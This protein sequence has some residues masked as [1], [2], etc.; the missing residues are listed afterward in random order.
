MRLPATL[1]LPFFIFQTWA[2]TLDDVSETPVTRVVELLKQMQ[3]SLQK[4]MDEDAALYDKL[5]CWCNNNKY[6]KGEA[7]SDA[8]AKVSDVMSTTESLTSRR[9]EVKLVIEQLEKSVADGKATLDQ[10]AEMREKEAAEFHGSE[11]DSIQAVE[12]LKAA[13]VVLSKHQGAALPQV[14]LTQ[15][16]STASFLALRGSGRKSG[17]RDIE[18][19]SRLARSFDEFLETHGFLGDS[20]SAT[21]ATVVEEETPKQ[22]QVNSKAA[23]QNSIIWS[24]DDTA[25]LQ[26]GLRTAS[27]FMQARGTEEYYPSYQGRSGEIVGILKELKEQMEADLSESQKTEISR[28]AAYEELRS[29]KSDEVAASEKQAEQKEDELAKISMDL[30]EAKED[31]DQT[32]ATLAENQ[33]FVANLKATC[34]DADGNFEQRKTTRM[35]EIKAVSD[36]ISILMEDSARDTMSRTYASFLQT[37]S[38]SSVSGATVAASK[39]AASAILREAAMRH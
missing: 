38:W 10:A 20:A 16:F 34:E 7:I 33:K 13:I 4:E 12:N 14:A 28:K 19:E 1:I 2:R 36:T 18:H 25:V 32:Q 9:S 23:A 11:L 15:A 27:N 3:A 26:R 31:L 37:A 39:E 29:S 17:R 21:T 22:R 35:E 5:A 30:A 8:E 6:E 24:T